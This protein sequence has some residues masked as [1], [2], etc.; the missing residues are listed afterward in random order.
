MKTLLFL[1]RPDALGTGL[2][3]CLQAEAGELELRRFPDGESYLRV[4][5]DPAGRDVVVCRS[6]D[7]PDEHVL[8]LL[9]L[10][11]TL[12]DLGAARV[13]LVAPYLAYMR[14]D[15]RFRAGEGVT[16]RYFAAMLSRHFDWMV[17]VDPHLH[18]YRGLDEI[19]TMPT[20][21]VAAMPDIARWIAGNVERP[22]V[23]GPDRESEQWAA[24]VAAA[25]GCP[26]RV[27]E[28]TRLG[29][30]RVEI[31]V[32]PAAGM[33]QHTPV[34]VDDI[35]SSGHT[36]ME[37]ARGLAGAGYRRPVCIGVHAVFS[38]GAWEEMQRAPIERVVTCNT[39]EHP[40]NGI[41]LAETIAA[42]L[43]ERSSFLPG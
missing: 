39:I 33:E 15:V 37:T 41:D 36:M 25:A 38:A 22:L 23:I 29:D 7:R 4:L 32:P 9:L 13:G 11:E 10:A 35:I 2:A 20:R 28:K 1:P 14:Q 27:L 26:Y 43:R 5:T 30:R 24:R 19:Y 42:A 16:S 21:V 3:R 12:R 31:R 34:L 8:P 18:R 17:T 40:T 6:L